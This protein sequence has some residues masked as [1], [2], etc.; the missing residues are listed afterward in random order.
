[1]SSD[2]TKVLPCAFCGENVAPINAARHGCFR[3]Y[4][5]VVVKDGK[6]RGE[7]L[8]NISGA[9]STVKNPNSRGKKVASS[10]NAS[11]SNLQ[12]YSPNAAASKSNLQQHSPNAASK[13]D[14]QQH[15]PNAATSTGSTVSHLV[16]TA[17]QVVDPEEKLILEVRDKEVL[18]NFTNKNLVQYRTKQNLDKEWKQIHLA[19][20]A[21]YPSVAVVKQKWKELEETYYDL[22]KDHK[23]K[24]QTRSGQAAPAPDSS[25][26]NW[27][28]FKIM[29][30]LSDVSISYNK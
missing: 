22:L 10:E 5:T 19:L 12:R 27:K 17:N 29:S 24:T 14:L 4:D 23:I 15:S 13:S 8:Q 30:F 11:K 9:V 28:Y 25:D 21:Y 16:Q 3:D 26:V 1:M 7:L 18:W 6:L 20:S 2:F